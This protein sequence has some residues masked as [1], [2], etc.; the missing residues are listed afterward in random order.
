MSE[1]KNLR[2]DWDCLY[3][4][5]KSV[6]KDRVICM[7]HKNTKEFVYFDVKLNRLLSKQEAMT[8]RLDVTGLHVIRR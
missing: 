2:H 1:L 3:T 4:Q 7:V 6:G 8:Y 5:F